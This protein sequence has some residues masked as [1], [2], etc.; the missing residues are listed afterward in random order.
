MS[1]IKKATFRG[2]TSFSP[3][4]VVLL[5]EMFRC[6]LRGGDVS[7]FVRNVYFASILRKI[8]S[9]ALLMRGERVAVKRSKAR[10]EQPKS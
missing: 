1:K 5:E 7:M 3:G 8:D 9:M 2:S 10:T 6:L 4:E